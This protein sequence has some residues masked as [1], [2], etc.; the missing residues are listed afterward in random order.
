[1]TEKINLIDFQ[2]LGGFCKTCL[3]T[4]CMENKKPAPLG[5]DLSKIGFFTSSEI[6][7][8]RYACTDMS[9]H[10]TKTAIKDTHNFLVNG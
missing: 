3:G 10:G 2:V 1:M 6:N 9:R 7:D 8:T 4:I 5:I